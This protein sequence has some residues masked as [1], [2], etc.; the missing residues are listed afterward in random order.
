M[1]IS[2]MNENVAP[3]KEA[4]LLAGVNITEVEVDS[5]FHYFR[6]EDD[7]TQLGFFRLGVDYGIKLLSQSLLTPTK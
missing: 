4:C 3:F 1:K 5:D 2:I 6:F 7:L